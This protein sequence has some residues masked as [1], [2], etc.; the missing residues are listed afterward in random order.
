MSFKFTCHENADEWFCFHT[1]VEPLNASF[2]LDPKFEEAGSKFQMKESKVAEDLAKLPRMSTLLS[3][4]GFW[5]F[6]ILDF[7]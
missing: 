2:K 3:F 5:N 1:L 6:F 7:Y 4:W